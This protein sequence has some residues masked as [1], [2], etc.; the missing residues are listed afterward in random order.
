MAAKA[1][2]LAMTAPLHVG[3]A[4]V[5]LEETLSYLPSDTLFSALVITWLE[6]NQ[7]ASW[8]D[9]MAGSFTTTPPL[10]LTS[11]MPYAGDVRL[12]PRPQL[13]MRST[14]GGKRFKGVRWVSE[15]IYKQLIQGISADDMEKLWEAA[16]VEIKGPRVRSGLLQGGAVWVTTKEREK[17]ATALG[18]PPKSELT[19]W[20]TEQAPRVTIDRI[21]NSSTLFHIGR[22]HFAKNCGLWCLSQGEE[23]WVAA[24]EN[25]LH[26]LADGGIGGLRSRGHGAFVL[27]YEKAWEELPAAEGGE[28]EVL[29]SRL[30]P[31]RAQMGFL[32]VPGASYQLVTVGGWS[33]GVGDT[34]L[35]RQR[36]RLLSEGSVVGRSE[37]A[38]GYLA[39]VNPDKAENNSGNASQLPLVDHPIFR[40]GF[41]VST[42]LKLHKNVMQEEKEL[43]T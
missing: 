8:V 2:R 24:A 39:N 6:T 33:Y 4:G 25:A 42:S 17:I 1:F 19:C 41:G 10:L 32:R 37:H 34:P 15:R 43:W 3:E 27:R 14:M 5:G 29:L 22:T 13:P 40:Y 9:A 26:L 16:S 12:F 20:G 35:I 28:H 7:Y 30:A 23:K 31:T 18:K 21:R 11:A 38:L 36:L